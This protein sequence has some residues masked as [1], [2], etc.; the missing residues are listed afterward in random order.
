MDISY[1]GKV[2]IL[3]TEF[4]DYEIF[5]VTSLDEIGTILDA[6]YAVFHG[7]EKLTMKNNLDLSSI[8]SVHKHIKN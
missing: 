4:E 2:Y 8:R 6:K 7:E 3:I 5:E 1:E